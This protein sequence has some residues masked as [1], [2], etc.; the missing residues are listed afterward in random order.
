MATTQYIGAR[1]VPLFADPADW[2]DT[3]VYEP[4]TIVLHEGNSFTS[5]QF[6]PKGIDI[7]NEEYWA[8]TGNYNAQIEQYRQDVQR[9]AT[10]VNAVSAAL[11][12]EVERAKKA[13]Q[14][15]AAAI[16]VNS[17]AISAELDRAK[18]AEKI[19]SDKIANEITRATSAE[20][21]I[22]NYIAPDILLIGDSYMEG[23]SP[24]GSVTS[25]GTRVKNAIEGS[26][27]KKVHIL[28]KGGYSFCNGTWESLLSDWVS[29]QTEETINK[30]GHVYIV[31]G[32][33][34][35][36]N[37]SNEIGTALKSFFTYVKTKFKNASYTIFFVGSGVENLATQHT[38]VTAANFYRVAVAYL[39]YA[40]YG[41]NFVDGSGVIK[42]N[43]YFSSD[44]FHPNESGQLMLAN[45]LMNIINGSEPKS[46]GMK[47]GN[48]VTIA[49]GN[50]SS[51]S[52]EDNYTIDND[53]STL[54]LTVYSKDVFYGGSSPW[55]NYEIARLD[56][57]IRFKEGSGTQDWGSKW[58]ELTTLKD[59]AIYQAPYDSTFSYYRMFPVKVQ[60]QLRNRTMPTGISADAWFTDYGYIAIAKNK[61]WLKLSLTTP[62]RQSGESSYLQSNILRFNIWGV[63]TGSF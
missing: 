3:R 31:G 41:Y 59:D 62:L 63:Q 10:Q 21:S 15:N 57:D 34:D 9:Y 29:K 5:R 44:Y 25:F 11:N 45:A 33:N 37:T 12:T 46:W 51:E 30:I 4:L 20:N 36:H 40:Y 38:D 56:G 32:A 24:D 47:Q 7:S 14:E 17:D 27:N 28:C 22:T 53:T 26:S 6:V 16:K 42:Y 50:T 60:Y 19:N 39:Y 13:E 43:K 18:S 49:S 55:N 58:I 52:T 54:N 23:Y 48:A 35:R 8:N 61:L 2:N 1:Y